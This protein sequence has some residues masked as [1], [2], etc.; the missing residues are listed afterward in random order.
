M[1]E[2]WEDGANEVSQKRK[3]EIKSVPF[4]VVRKN[5]VNWGKKH[6]LK[7]YNAY[8]GTS[9]DYILHEVYPLIKGHGAMHGTYADLQILSSIL[10]DGIWEGTALDV[11]GHGAAIGYDVVLVIPFAKDFSA[12]NPDNTYP[13]MDANPGSSSFGVTAHVTYPSHVIAIN[14]DE[15]TIRLMKRLAKTYQDVHFVFVTCDDE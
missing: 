13:D 4:S 10:K 8:N 5:A 1:C 7:S 9:S 3:E 14:G 11:T 15:E 12:L 6:S 2:A